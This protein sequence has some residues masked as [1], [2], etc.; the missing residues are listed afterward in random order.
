M[1]FGFI[2]PMYN[3]SVFSHL[4]YHPVDGGVIAA[5]EE[6]YRLEMKRQVHP[7]SLTPEEA[8][9]V[10]SNIDNRGRYEHSEH[11]GNFNSGK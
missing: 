11:S 4:R 7:Q 1:T 3:S 9:I 8:D 2:L 6:A 10:M 5:Q